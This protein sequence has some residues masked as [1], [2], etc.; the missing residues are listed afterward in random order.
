[1]GQ[2]LILFGAVL[3]SSALLLV[4]GAVC[5]GVLWLVLVRWIGV[6]AAIPGALAA[7]VVVFVEV[8]AATELLGPLY[9]RLD[10]LAIER[11]E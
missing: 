6:A 8:L 4:P 11:T 3:L 9:E 10:I 7:T 2:R 1:M 5:G